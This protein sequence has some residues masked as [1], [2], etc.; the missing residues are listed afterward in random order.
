MS[1][2]GGGQSEACEPNLTAMLDLILQIL[3]FFICT[4]NFATEAN[5]GDVPLPESQTARTI[6]KDGAKDPIFIN[7]L[8]DEEDRRHKVIFPLRYRVTA[9]GDQEPFPPIPQAEARREIQKMYD[10][11]SRLEK[12]VKNHVIIRAHKDAEYNEVFQLLQ[13]CS[14]AGFRNLNVRALVK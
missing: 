11:I 4:V 13:S 7:L 2:G 9:T 12:E 6:P 14:D 5:F 3:M 1:H 10:D 8:F